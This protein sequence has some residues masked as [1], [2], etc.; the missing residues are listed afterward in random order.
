MFKPE[1]LVGQDPEKLIKMTKK[2]QTMMMFATVSGN[3]TKRETEEI[4]QIWWAALKNALYDVTKYVYLKNLISYKKKTFLFRYIVD[5]SRVLFLLQDGSQAY[6]VKDFLV[7]QDR[8]QEVTI[9]NRPYYGKGAK[10][11]K[12]NTS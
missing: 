2:G 7:Q 1:E 6:E 9:D 12:K 4:T 8:C 3:P 11:Q 5:D 10:V